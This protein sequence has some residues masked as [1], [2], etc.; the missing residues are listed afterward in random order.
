MMPASGRFEIPRGDYTSAYESCAPGALITA[1]N[2]RIQKYTIFMDEA[3]AK[4]LAK[5]IGGDE[6]AMEPE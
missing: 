1:G 5:A 3:Q 2:R 6:S 4:S